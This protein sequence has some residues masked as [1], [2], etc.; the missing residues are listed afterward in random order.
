M[1]DVVL[2]VVVEDVRVLSAAP[3]GALGGAL[4]GSP[5]MRGVRPPEPV[6]VLR[7]GGAGTSPVIFLYSSSISMS[8]G[9]ATVADAGMF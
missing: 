4:K 5:L 8:K 1:V 9:S 6:G 3:K 2:V 7:Y